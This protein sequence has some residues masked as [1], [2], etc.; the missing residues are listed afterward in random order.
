MKGGSTTKIL[1]ELIL[2]SGLLQASKQSP[3]DGVVLL[4]L[5]QRVL[6][7]VLLHSNVSAECIQLAGNR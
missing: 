6:D 2:W 7:T 5:Y 3:T 1:L 4:K